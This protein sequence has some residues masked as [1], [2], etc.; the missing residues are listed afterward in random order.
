MSYNNQQGGSL[1]NLFAFSFPGVH[2]LQISLV[3]DL[4]T[5][6]S[7]KKKHFCFISLVPGKKVDQSVSASGRTFDWQS[8]INMKA[9]ADRILGLS[10]ALKTLAESAKYFYNEQTSTTDQGALFAIRQQQLMSKTLQ[11]SVAGFTLFADSSRSSYSGGQGST[12]SF[13]LQLTPDQKKPDRPVIILWGK[14][15]QGNSQAYSMNPAQATAIA[16]VCDFIGQK[17]LELEFEHESNKTAAPKQNN[18]QSFHNPPATTP[19]F[20]QGINP[21]DLPAAQ[22]EEQSNTPER[23]VNNFGGALDNMGGPDGPF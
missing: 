9:D 17:C 15:G 13:S 11:N 20:D 19:T 18:P 10:H 21:A 7:Y 22:P 16:K 2:L 8:R 12:K 1:K 6:D 23:V 3:K 14:E 5:E 4:S